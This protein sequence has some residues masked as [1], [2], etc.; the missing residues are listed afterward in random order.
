[1]I[2]NRFGRW[3]WSVGLC[4]A[5]VVLLSFNSGLLERFQPSAQYL[6]SALLLLGGFGF[7][8]AYAAA[9][10]NWWRLMP[11]WTLIA[12]SIMSVLS[13]IETINPRLNAGLLFVG[14]AVAFFH[15]YL[16]RRREHWWTIIPGG[17]MLVI[18][19]V[20]G[21]SSIVERAETLGGIL[22]VGMGAVFLLLYSLGRTNHR[23]WSLIPASILG[24]FGLFVFS[25]NGF[26]PERE[27]TLFLQWWPVLLILL[28]GFVGYRTTRAPL[29][30]E[31]IIVKSAPKSNY[32][33]K[34]SDI[35]ALSTDK[36]SLLSRLSPKKLL[37]RSSRSNATETT[38]PRTISREGPHPGTS[39]EILPED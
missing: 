10:E 33:P 9:K 35:P 19:V 29:K 24:I 37:P 11:A 31:K 8:G 1:M 27:A 16:L 23:W 4:L 2:E 6:L 26:G 18:G 7:F 14:L 32:K 17:F 21:L 20:V 22:F 12:L 39:I 3:I 15:I 5:G 38:P 28:G 34:D 25:L 13:V 30:P 36:P